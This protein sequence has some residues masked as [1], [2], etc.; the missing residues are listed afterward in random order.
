MRKGRWKA[1]S[2]GPERAHTGHHISAG[3]DGWELYD[4]E[5]DRC[6][7]ND[8]SNKHP[9]LVAELDRLWTDW[10]DECRVQKEAVLYV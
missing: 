5:A 4:T 6:E 9:D 3:H 10:F 8:V 7:S 2:L 1:V